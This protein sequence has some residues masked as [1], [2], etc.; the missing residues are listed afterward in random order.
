MRMRCSA[1]LVRL[2]STLPLMLVL[3][4]CT[5]GGQFDP[6]EIFSSDMFST[7]TKLQGKREPL[8][9]NGVP[10]VTTGVPADLYKGYQ[11]PPDQAADNGDAAFGIAPGA[12]PATEAAKPEP[13]SKPMPK[14]K[15]ARKPTHRRTQIEVGV[16]PKPAH[17]RKRTQ[18]SK[19]IWPAPPQPP[20]P[21]QSAQSVWPAPPQTAQPSQSIWPAPPQTAPVEQ[22]AQPSQSIWPNP[23]ASS[24]P[25]Q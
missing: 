2:G 10:G 15:L 22:T 13:K 25:S 20:Q 1:S 19:S 14:P 7:K 5:P 4:G 23:S 12:V 16:A 24:V 3:I 8:F 21:A 6:T 17:A 18:A 11:P 9:P